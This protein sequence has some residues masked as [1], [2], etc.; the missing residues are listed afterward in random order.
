MS[1]LAK[2]IQQ[3]IATSGPITFAWFMEQALYHPQWGYYTSP[4]TKIGRTGDFYTA[5]TVNPLF[6]TMLARWLYQMWDAADRPAQW[7]VAEYGPGTGILARDI[8]AAL[9]RNHPDLYATLNY[10]LIEISDTLKELQQ[11]TLTTGEPGADHKFHWVNRLA[12]ISP[13]YITN[14]CILANELVDA[15]PVHLVR[16][17]GGELQEMYV[18]L[19]NKEG[20]SVFTFVPGPLSTPELA[21][22]F[23][24]QNVQLEEG[25]RAEVNLQA[26][27]WLAEVTAHLQR[28]YLLTID[29]GATSE[30]LYAPFRHDGT[31]RCFHKHHLVDNPLTNLG[32]QDITAHVNFSTLIT[33]GE[34]LELRKKELVSQP[35]FLINLGI[36]DILKE[37][38]D[39]TQ[40]P[41]F[42][43]ITSAIKQLVLPGGMGGIFKVLVQEKA[44]SQGN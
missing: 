8:V 20:D 11:Q 28:G 17:S 18:S 12:E 5:P 13:G 6:G 16:Q 44:V 38:P 2:L 37:Q 1:D 41:E 22:Y 15:F 9:R 30:E 21:E 24:S 36:L 35:Q 29:Y 4:G 25:Q 33:W 42:A 14:G 31:L 32:G 19:S 27:E 7:V 43:K 10:Y 39:Y 40:D 34:Q 26:R 23:N 3:E